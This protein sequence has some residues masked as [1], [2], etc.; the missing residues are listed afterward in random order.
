MNRFSSMDTASLIECYDS[1]DTMQHKTGVCHDGLL[2]KVIDEY[3]QDE[4]DAR[5]P[6][7]AASEDLLEEIA[8][9]WIHDNRHRHD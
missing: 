3:D 9:R 5:I 1:W 7:R 8:H 4:R 6:V 2:R